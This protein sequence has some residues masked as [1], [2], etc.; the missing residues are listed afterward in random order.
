MLRSGQA[1]ECDQPKLPNSCANTCDTDVHKVRD[2]HGERRLGFLWI[3][4]RVKASKWDGAFPHAAVSMEEAAS[5]PAHVNQRRSAL[6]EARPGAAF[7][8]RVSGGCAAP[9]AR[10]DLG[11]YERLSAFV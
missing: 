10:P 4:S 9:A 7:R 6:I 2:R 1:A 8:A 3:L 5:A 11:S